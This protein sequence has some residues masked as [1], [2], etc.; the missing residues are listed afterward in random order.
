M[1]VTNVKIREIYELKENRMKAM[2]SIVLEDCL[3]VH[4][5]R[6]IEGNAGLFVAMP[7]QKRYD[8][9]FKD[10]V[11]PIIKDLR[12]EITKKVLDAYEQEKAIKYYKFLGMPSTVIAAMNIQN[13]CR[14][15][16]RDIGSAPEKL[17][18]LIGLSE[19]I[20]FLVE[21]GEELLAN[22]VKRK[23]KSEDVTEVTLYSAT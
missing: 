12:I 20:E 18:C 23:D 4:G 22:K 11:H 10:I 19:V 7:S 6:V 3:A 9:D 15:Y 13:A 17:P 8:S 16:L 14:L 21:Q 2:V 5:I 1:K